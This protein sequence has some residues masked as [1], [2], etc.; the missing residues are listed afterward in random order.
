MDDINK[1]AVGQRI[2]KIRMDL[3]LSME[4]FGE[5]LKT[6][7]GAVNNWEKGKNLPNNSRLV[8]IATLGKTTLEQLLYGS[9]NEALYSLILYINNYPEIN[10]LSWSEFRKKNEDKLESRFLDYMSD[11][12]A[13]RRLIPTKIEEPACFRKKELEAFTDEERNQLEAYIN[14]TEEEK[15]I[16]IYKYAFDSAT[17]SNISP[18]DKISLMGILA[19]TSENLAMGFEKSDI[20]L[21]TKALDA[22]KNAYTEIYSLIYRY[23][24]NTLKFS[25]SSQI[26]KEMEDKILTPLE[27][28]KSHYEKIVKETK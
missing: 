5:R 23:D 2:K 14:K 10:S 19:E 28:L 25:R 6:S 7:K 17:R 26:S 27:N 8:T 18:T 4:E 22:V 13:W 1:E 15:N 11:Y 20:G 21:A 12:W 24:R 16:K 3:G 9:L